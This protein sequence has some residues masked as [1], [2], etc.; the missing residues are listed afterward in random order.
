M[1]PLKLYFFSIIAC[2]MFHVLLTNT[3]TH[4]HTHLH[5][6]MYT[7]MY[8]HACIVS[9]YIWLNLDFIYDRKDGSCVFCIWLILHIIIIF[10]S[11]NFLQQILWFYYNEWFKASI[12][13]SHHN[14]FM[15]LF[16]WTSKLSSF[17][18]LCIHF[19]FVFIKQW[20]KRK[21]C[22]QKYLVCYWHV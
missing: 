21:Q 2:F 22:K 14:F 11:I 17:I 19:K 7:F 5:A 6:Y 15:H 4:T 8:A 9:C 13:I 20:K 1:C 3:D 10:N 16:S 18:I 12:V